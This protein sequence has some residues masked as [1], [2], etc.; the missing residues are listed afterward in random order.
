MFGANLCFK[1]STRCIF[2]IFETKKIGCFIIQPPLEMIILW[3]WSSGDDKVVDL[4]E[5]C[6]KCYPFQLLLSSITLEDLEIVITLE[7]LEIANEVG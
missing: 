5:L 2:L 1:A 7:D 6:M 4:Q 3:E